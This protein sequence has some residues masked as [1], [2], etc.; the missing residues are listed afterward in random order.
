MLF[1]KLIRFIKGSVTITAKGKFPERF[2]NVC[3]NKEIIVTNVE[4]LSENCIMCTMSLAAFE[5]IDAISKKT[6][7]TIDVIS[8]KGLPIILSKYK[9]RFI[10]LIGPA[11]FVVSLFV[12]NLFVW[13]IEIV[14][15][16]K[17]LPKEIENN[18]KELG[19]RQGVLRFL[20]DETDVKSEMLMK[21]PELCE[22]LYSF[23]KASSRLPIYRFF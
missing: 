4:Y 8:K 3:A 21:M 18:L 19:V 13:D 12:L 7:V 16:E 22:A 23:Q 10:V 5:E 9:K 20:I 11:F 2:L 17:V 1:E 6:F 14:G 15:C